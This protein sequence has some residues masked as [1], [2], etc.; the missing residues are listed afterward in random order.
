MPTFTK[1]FSALIA[2]SLSVLCSLSAVAAE[3]AKPAAAAERPV[4]YY[5]E[6]RPI[7]MAQCQGCHQPAKANGGYSMTEF[8]KLLAGG[9]SGEEDDHSGKPAGNQLL[10]MI[11]PR[12][13]RLRCPKGKDLCRPPN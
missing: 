10:T 12:M 7:F 3:P 4:S 11:T 5:K 8:A 13:G 9:D 1:L 2:A 6:I